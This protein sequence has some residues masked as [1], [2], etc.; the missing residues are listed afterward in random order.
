MGL[1]FRKINADDFPLCADI[2]VSAY[3][4][5]PWYNSWTKE[6]A[7]LRIEATMSG[8]NARGYVARKTIK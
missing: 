1:T 4:G 3:K 6:E 5:A 8:F 2:L 7:Q